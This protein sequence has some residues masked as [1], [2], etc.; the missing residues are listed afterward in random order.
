MQNKPDKEIKGRSLRTGVSGPTK[1]PP[2][3]TAQVFTNKSG[4]P[5]DASAGRESFSTRAHL[6]IA[7][8]TAS[9]CS[10]NL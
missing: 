9:S 5:R 4:K 2:R 8:S 3:T 7:G 10:G 6:A 1:K